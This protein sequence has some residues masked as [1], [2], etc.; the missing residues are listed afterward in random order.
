MAN[1]LWELFVRVSGDNSHFK[2]TIKDSQGDLSAF[3]RTAVAATNKIGDAFSA[4][5]LRMTGVGIA[6]YIFSVGRDF[7]NASAKIAKSTGEVGQNLAG[8]NESFKRLYAQ[9]GRSAEEIAD[10]LAKIRAET[11][12]SGPALEALTAANLKFAK[13]TSSEVG[14]AVDQTQELFQN[15]GVATIEQADKLDVLYATMTK[16]GI[17]LSDLSGQLTTLG[18][19]ARSFGLSFEQTAAL[20]ASFDDAG[21]K[22]SDMVRGLNSLFLKFSEAGKDPQKALADLIDRLKDTKTQTA[23]VNELVDAG[24]AKRSAVAMAD[25]ARRGALEFGDLA[26]ELENS[27]GKIKEVAEET[28]TLGDRWAELQHQFALSAEPAGNFIVKWAADS[29]KAVNM[30]SGAVKLAFGMATGTIQPTG[31]NAADYVTNL[32][33][34]KPSPAGGGG[35]GTGGG[36]AS[37]QGSFLVSA[38]IQADLLA[39]AIDRAKQ[40]ITEFYAAGTA[41][42]KKLDAAFSDTTAEA[43][44]LRFQL[45]EAIYTANTV[46]IPAKTFAESLSPAI[47]E[48]EAAMHALG[49]TSTRELRAVY[50]AALAAARAM[51]ENGAS[52]QDVGAAMERVAEAHA[53]L[54]KRTTDWTKGVGEARK[55]TN[56]F[57]KQIDRSFNRLARGI[58]DSIVNWKGFG[59]TLK[60]IAKDT[61][62]SFLEI[63]IRQ[64]IK[65]LEEQFSKLAGALGKALG[66]GGGAAQKAGTGG[67]WFDGWGG[68]G[69]KSAGSAAGGA[70][71]I[72]GT[73]GAVSAAVGAVSSVIGNFQFAGMNKSL[74]V[75]VNHSLR[76]FN[77]AA[78]TLDFLYTWNSQWF[79]RTGEMWQAIIDVKDAISRGGGSG[80]GRGGLTFNNCS[81]NG[82]PQQNAAAIFQYAELAG[83]L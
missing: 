1:S 41:G 20:V 33:A 79:T 73:I 40:H 76:Q 6:A 46:E 44:K 48:S 45:A 42:G 23:A 64:L 52:V 51:V 3:E 14:A 12:L 8:L 13:V 65:P 82:T 50:D 7:E 10:G 17:S 47:R 49:I 56:E 66:I 22:A 57:Q 37:K 28:K 30:V 75:L 19:T 59:N 34:P 21:L 26:K 53:K 43:T 27:K 77:V 60:E 24:F 70:G 29:L 83:V 74:D 35:G 4:L 68:G 55:E 16:A 54:S 32:P 58:A 72:M 63:M 9:S 39:Q 78:Q 2:R 69:S 31:P 67:G 11:K 71:G 38:S 15:W 80:G 62:S 18:P 25:A 61:A 5:G 36:G 81:F